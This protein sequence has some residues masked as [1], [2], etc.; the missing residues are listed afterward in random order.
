[1]KPH[2]PDARERSA[3][4]RYFRPFVEMFLGK[5]KVLEL[6]CGQGFFLEAL[7]GAGV[8]CLGIEVDEGLY[9]SASS[10]G[11]KVLR[12]DIFDYLRTTVDIFD[13]CFASHIVEHF[14]PNEVEELFHLVSRVTDKGGLL[15]IVTPNIANLRRA[16]GD[17]WRDPT[18]VRPYPIPA[19]AK[20]LGRQG[21]QVTGS[22]YHTD[23][24]FSL[25]RQIV[26]AL[27]NLLIGHYWGEDDLYVTAQKI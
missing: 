13:G 1:M 2:I 11:L 14:P 16:V 26:Y 6:A 12:A 8:D 5:K 27:R 15:V 24:P 4:E 10:R 21:W 7:Q 17:F 25:R 23:R 3:A 20:L 9:Q 18:H 19:L 22:G